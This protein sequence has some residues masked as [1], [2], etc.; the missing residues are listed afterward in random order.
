MRLNDQPHELICRQR[1]DAK[2][3]VAHDFCVA[4]HAHV[5]RA[6]LILEPGIDAL[7]RA[8]LVVADVLL[9]MFG[10]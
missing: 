10:T 7:G 2:H 6:E 5:A 1:E 9:S 4:A 8:S 3:Q